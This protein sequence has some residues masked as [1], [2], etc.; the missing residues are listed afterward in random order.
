MQPQQNPRASWP[1]HD[2]NGGFFLVICVVGAAALAFVAWM[3][4][5]GAIS[6]A[7]MALHHYKISLLQ[8][9]TDRFDQADAQMAAADPEAVGVRDLYSIARA[10]GQSFL[11]PAVAFM[12]TLAGVCMWRAAPSR[13]KRAFDL[14][15]L[16]REQARSFPT[17]AAFARRHPGLVA[18]APDVRP[19]D[20]ALLPEEWAERHAR[21]KDGSFDEAAA[22]RALALQL[23]PP[24]H[25]V[26]GAAP[27]VRA[28]FAVFALHRMERR[29]EALHLLGRLSE[30]LAA[31]GKDKPGGPPASLTLP[32]AAMRAVDAVLGQ[33]D[34]VGPAA[35]VCA[36]HAYTHTALMALL[37]EARR[38]AGVLAPAQFVWLKLLDRPLWYA[39]HSLGFETEGFGRHLHPNP[40]IEA[41]G[42]RD[43]WAAERV[44]GRPLV[45]PETARALDA[46]RDALR[47][48]PSPARD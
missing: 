11:V 20:L 18:P 25:G 26:A 23:G 6:S 42:A 17:A 12:L 40:C 24:W 36:R 43:H 2:D 16:V 45:E 22:R 3:N 9:F 34:A 44:A 21:R 30:A 10:V 27:P 35:A 48:R 46:V 47:T 1:S 31:P 38:K 39:L 8:H 13:Y 29:R 7:V 15:G 14:D 5:H 4:W 19:L 33:A 32:R 41:A 37:N 28:V